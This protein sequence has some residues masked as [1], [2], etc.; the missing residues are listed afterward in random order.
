MRKHF[1]AHRKNSHVFRYLHHNRYGY[2]ILPAYSVLS[3]FSIYD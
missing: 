3:T 2:L 1:F